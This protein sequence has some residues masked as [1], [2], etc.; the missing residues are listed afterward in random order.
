M[1]KRRVAVQDVDQPQHL[2]GF[3]K[4]QTLAVKLNLTKATYVGE[5]VEG[6]RV[7]APPEPKT[8]LREVLAHNATFVAIRLSRNRT[9]LVAR[10][11]SVCPAP[12]AGALFTCRN[13]DDVLERSRRFGQMVCEQLVP[14][15]VLNRHVR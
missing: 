13:A 14:N 4:G 15:M 2:H 12:K 8:T 1:A 10:Q 11:R 3:E 9:S 7:L 6:V 5:T